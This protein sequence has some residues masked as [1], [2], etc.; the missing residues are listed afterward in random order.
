MD[1]AGLTVSSLLLVWSDRLL[2]G[3][4]GISIF[5]SSAFLS[6][7]SE[8]GA[9]SHLE[10]RAAGVR[11]GVARFHGSALRTDNC[12]HINLCLLIAAFSSC[13]FPVLP[14]HSIIVQLGF[15]KSW[16]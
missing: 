10:R 7:I 8:A 9:P 1:G 11:S 13:T 12:L 3:A 6:L 15:L 2:V 4:R 14:S 5:S 16:V